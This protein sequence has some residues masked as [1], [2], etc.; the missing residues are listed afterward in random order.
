MR[1]YFSSIISHLTDPMAMQNIAFMTEQIKADNDHHGLCHRRKYPLIFIISAVLFVAINASLLLFFLRKSSP[2]D[3]TVSITNTTSRTYY[4][5]S[6]TVPSTSENSGSCTLPLD[7]SCTASTPDQTKAEGLG[8]FYQ[9]PC[10][11]VGCNFYRPF[12]RL[13]AK[14]SSKIN[15]PYVKCPECVPDWSMN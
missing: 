14:H 10:S 2:V 6:T 11:G 1:R 5:M 3:P 7:K 8:V 15:D 12:C 13:C 9:F 4:T